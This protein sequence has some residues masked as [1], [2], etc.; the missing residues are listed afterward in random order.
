MALLIGLGNNIQ[1]VFIAQLIP[2][3]IIGIMARS[4]GIDVELLHD[5]NVLNHALKGHNIAAIGIH[6]VSIGTFDEHRL[7]INQQL[8]VFDFHL[9]EPYFLRDNLL[10]LPLLVFHRRHK[11]I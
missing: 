9:A 1:S 2:P 11:C 3:R 4:N 6:L 7:A 10:H 8:P 5:F